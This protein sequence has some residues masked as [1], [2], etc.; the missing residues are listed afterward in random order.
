MSLVS[1]LQDH[2][3][4]V[5][6]REDAKQ[7]SKA[8]M[9]P[10]AIFLRDGWLYVLMTPDTIRALDVNALCRHAQDPRFSLADLQRFHVCSLSSVSFL[11]LIE[12]FYCFR[13]FIFIIKP[14][15]YSPCI[16]LGLG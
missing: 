6:D 13:E 2:A 4:F 15:S 16:Q 5:E 3:L 14:Y 11:Y 7:P 1:L 8:S 9:S 12:I 10:L